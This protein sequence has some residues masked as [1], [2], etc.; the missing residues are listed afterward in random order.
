M[1]AAH[2][3][4]PR[5][6]HVDEGLSAA[7][8]VGGLDF[9][10]DSGSEYD[11]LDENV[12]TTSRGSQTPEQESSQ[13]W[14]DSDVPEDEPHRHESSPDEEELGYVSTITEPVENAQGGF[15]TSAS[16]SALQYHE[17]PVDSSP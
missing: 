12:T 4:R 15:R 6:E 2:V 9:D 7:D 14:S 16:V 11:S 5:N 17:T 10:S 3:F 1:T 13:P 8:K